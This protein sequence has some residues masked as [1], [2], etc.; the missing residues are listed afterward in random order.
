M[1]RSQ[2]DNASQAIIR[3]KILAARSPRS[4]QRLAECHCRATIVRAACSDRQGANAASRAALDMAL[5]PHGSQKPPY[6]GW[7]QSL[8]YL[9]AMTAFYSE[10]AR[11]ED[12]FQCYVIPAQLAAHN[13]EAAVNLSLHRAN[14]ILVQRRHREAAEQFAV[15]AH[16]NDILN[17]KSSRANCL[18]GRAHCLVMDGGPLPISV[19]EDCQ[20]AIQL[21]SSSNQDPATLGSA[22]TLTAKGIIR[23]LVEA[24]KTK[25]EDLDLQT[26]LVNKGQP[27]LCA[28]TA[29][30][31]SIR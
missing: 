15:A 12:E 9:L 13:P 23:R 5:G 10:D 27:F 31:A 6:K 22:H 25:I 24:V 26:M 7:P 20:L 18:T 17:R 2:L 30:Q 4:A 1:D 14:A 28:C 8:Q 19:I 29:S 11:A 16:E 21:L 3:A